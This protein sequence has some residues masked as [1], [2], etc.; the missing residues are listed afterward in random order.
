ME[1][2]ID[3]TAYQAVA[4]VVEWSLVLLEVGGAQA[5]SDHHVVAFEDLVHHGRRRIRGVGVVAVGH[6]VHVG[7]DVFEHGADHVALALRGSLRTIAPSL[8]AISAVRS[9]ELLSYT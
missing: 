2:A 6:D 9:V 3:G 1:Q 7:V 4:E 5:V 8:V